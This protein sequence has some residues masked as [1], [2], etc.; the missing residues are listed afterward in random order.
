MIPL[1]I[2]CAAFVLI[3]FALTVRHQSAGVAR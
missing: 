2:T 3:A 1:T